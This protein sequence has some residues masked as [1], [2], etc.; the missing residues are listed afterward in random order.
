MSWLHLDL[1]SIAERPDEVV[2]EPFREGVRIH[3]L[4]GGDSSEGPAAALLRYEPGARVPAH[5]HTGHEH[6]L[7]LSGAQQDHRGRYQAGSVVVNPPGSVHAVSSPEGCLVLAIWE[8]PVR[9]RAPGADEPS[10]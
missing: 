2:W 10:Y 8:R 1:R 6:I 3:R 5:E 4:Y 7:V 9:F